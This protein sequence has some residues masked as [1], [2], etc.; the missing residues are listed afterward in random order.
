MVF[1]AA[2]YKHV[3]LLEKNEFRGV[4]NNVV[5]TK[6]V[7]DACLAHDVHT[8]VLIS[9]DKAVH[10]TSVMGMSKRVA[11]LIV[12]EAR[13]RRGDRKTKFATVRFGNVLGS[14][15]SVIPIFEEQIASGGP[16]TVTHPEV[17]RYFMTISEA[18]ALVIQAGAMAE[19]TNG[20]FV[21][22]MG[23]PLKIA[24]LAEQIIEM[25][26][27]EPVYTTP[28]NTN[29]IQIIFSGLKRGEKLHEELFIKGRVPHPTTHPRIYSSEESLGREGLSDNLLRF[30]EILVSSDG[31][32]KTVWAGH[33]IKLLNAIDER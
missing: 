6:I 27:K 13:V 11:E 18:S 25:A 33:L 2:A 31:S 8:M 30:W 21:L 3:H 4:Y 22:D 17:T 5:G 20:V 15:G 19:S 26:G 28:I 29:E 24:T 7:V 10:P 9:T 23:E 16:V 14:N 32:E 1:H 12:E